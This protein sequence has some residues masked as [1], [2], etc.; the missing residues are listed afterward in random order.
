M[1]RKREMYDSTYVFSTDQQEEVKKIYQKY[2]PL[3]KGKNALSEEEEKMEKLRKLDK[4]VTRAGTMASLIT[5]IG[6]ALVH[7]IGITLV[8]SRSMFALGTVIAIIGLIFFLVS[9]PVY[10]FV[11]KKQRRRVEAQILKLCDEL[12]K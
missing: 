6:G 12:M 3:E 1:D 9:Y 10:C 7:S 11:V 4:S 5:G 8:Q 2:L